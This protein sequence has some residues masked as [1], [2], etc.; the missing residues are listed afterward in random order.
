MYKQKEE[1]DIT[2]HYNTESE[3]KNESFY[4]KNY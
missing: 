2:F 3:K 4:E 1:W